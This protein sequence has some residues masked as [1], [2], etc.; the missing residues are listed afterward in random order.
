MSGINTCSEC[1]GI[2][3]L[4][5]SL[6]WMAQSWPVFRKMILCLSD[7]GLS[8]FSSKGQQKE[9]PLCVFV[10][11]LVIQRMLT[12]YVNLSMCQL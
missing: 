1:L 2:L 10:S 4:E 12:I 3:L 7:I 6:E 11:P 9:T 5:F 8:T